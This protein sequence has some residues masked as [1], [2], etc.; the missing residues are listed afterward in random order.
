[1]KLI[2]EM[3]RWE[4]KIRT[5]ELNRIPIMIILGEQ[6]ISNN[7]ISVRR[8]HKG[9]LGSLDLKTFINSIQNE[10]NNRLSSSDKI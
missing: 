9:N 8:K 6:E 7:T 3:K 10:V 4:Q 1:M 2:K 5:A